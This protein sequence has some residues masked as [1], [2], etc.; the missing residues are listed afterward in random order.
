M[1]RFTKLGVALAIGAAALITGAPSAH[2]VQH[3]RYCPDWYGVMEIGDSQDPA[4]LAADRNDND[5]ICAR[6][7]DAPGDAPQYVDDIPAYVPQ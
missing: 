4:Q 2:A 1:N 5:L 6:Y 7:S 3:N